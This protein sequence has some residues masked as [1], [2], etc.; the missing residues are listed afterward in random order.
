[1]QLRAAGAELGELMI[2]RKPAVIEYRRNVL[3]S[4]SD[5][6]EYAPLAH[7]AASDVN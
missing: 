2:E 3:R 4:V 5:I 1:M 6:M 7:L